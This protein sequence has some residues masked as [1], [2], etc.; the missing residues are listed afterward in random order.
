[1]IEEKENSNFYSDTFQEAINF[2]TC[3]N[4][5]LTHVTKNVFDN[6]IGT[7]MY[8][9]RKTKDALKSHNDL[10]QFRL[11]TE[12]HPKLRSNGKHYLPPA[13]YS[14][15]VEEKNIFSM[16]TWGVST[17]GF[18]VQHQQTS[19]NERLVYVLVRTCLS[20][21]QPHPHRVILR[22]L[23]NMVNSFLCSSTNYFEN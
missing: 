22:H 3:H 4:I 14:V 23:L 8:M 7:L 5:D 2:E 13:S 18:L 21:I 1:V 10:V 12:L 20:W 19:L 6:I 15:I 9:S 11:R 17:H 16:P